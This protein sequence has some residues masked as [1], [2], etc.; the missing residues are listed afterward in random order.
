LTLERAPLIGP[1]VSGVAIV[2][3]FPG[4]GLFPLAWFALVP[5]LVFVVERRSWR[6]LLAGHFIFSL[7]YFGGVLY[8]IPHVLI[9]YGELARPIA[10]VLLVLLAFLMS[11]F[12]LPFSFLSQW[13][14]RRSIR[15]GLACAPLYWVLTEWIRNYLPFGGF[16]WAR[17]ADTQLP[18]GPVVQIADLGGVY[19]ISCLVAASNAALVL[20][21][22]RRELQPLMLLAILLAAVH[23]YGFY[24][25]YVWSPGTT[26]NLRVALVQGN[27]DSYADQEY[28][29]R[30]YFEALPRQYEEAVGRGAQLVILPEAQNPY[31]LESDFYFRTFWQRQVQRAGGA[32]LLNSSASEAEG[33]YYNSAYLLER[34]GSIGY[35]YDKIHLVP[36]GEYLPLQGLFGFASPIVAEVSGFTAGAEMNAGSVEGVSFATLICYE[37]IFPELTRAATA[38]Q[39]EIL[40]NITNDGWYGRT[41]APR[42]HLVQAAFRSIESRRYMLRAANTGYSAIISPWGT[43]E[44]VTELF[45]TS[46][47][48]ADVPGISSTTIYSRVGDLPIL[49]LIIG[50]GL[51]GLAVRKRSVFERSEQAWKT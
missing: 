26:G 31:F 40:V 29:A 11:C 51:W 47:L 49:A 4:P 10:W 41:A 23:L 6:S 14:G 39:A 3:C 36:F 24:R 32:L 35:R 2:L 33:V 20:A 7:V 12:L 37:A 5:L 42:Q 30:M 46:I 15:A 17:L 48:V 8:W 28:Y 45:E 38:A 50:G 43:M 25:L 18:Y 27:V 9:V 1:L 22:R 34:D 16:P 13:T 19:W 44:Q 21:L